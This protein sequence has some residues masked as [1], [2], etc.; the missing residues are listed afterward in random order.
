VFASED[1]LVLVVVLGDWSVYAQRSCEWGWKCVTCGEARR[2]YSAR[3][4]QAAVDAAE[5]H[6]H[7][8]QRQARRR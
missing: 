4:K 5:S 8:H 3:W 7:W 2:G 1:P 6:Y